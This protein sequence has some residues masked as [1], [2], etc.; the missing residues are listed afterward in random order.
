[1]MSAEL[2]FDVDIEDLIKF[3]FPKHIQHPLSLPRLYAYA[4]YGPL[5]T[6]GNLRSG[7]R[8][9]HT[10]YEY[11]L[12]NMCL[13]FD[14]E[15]IIMIFCEKPHQAYELSTEQQNTIWNQADARLKSAK[16]KAMMP[17]LTELDIRNVL[18][19]VPRNNQ[20]YL[21]FHEIQKTVEA[22]REKRIKDFK[23][24]YPPLATRPS[25]FDE[26][27]KSL[28]K[29]KP[30]KKLDMKVIAT[31]APLTMFQKGMGKSDAEVVFQATKNLSKHAFKISAF[32]EEQKG[33]QQNMM[34]LREMEPKLASPYVKVGAYNG[35]LPKQISVKEGWDNTATTKG[36]ALGSMV[37]ATPSATTWKRL[38]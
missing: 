13:Q 14:R 24:V 23:L 25:S 33:L 20:G 21:S 9:S 7:P 28:P 18:K 5:D 11:E 8:N 4:Y 36:V 27:R 17:V 3:I 12:E 37:K 32:G 22:Y 30:P 2:V 26:D 1:M 29:S 31:V 15:D 35:R 10:L 34:L 38:A 19:D 16:G 6:E